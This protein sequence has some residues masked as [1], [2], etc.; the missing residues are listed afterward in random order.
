[1]IMYE[2][3]GLAVILLIYL[4]VLGVIGIA[5]LAAY[6]LQ[7]VGMYTLGKNRGMKYPWLAFI[8]YARVY[9]QGELCGPLAFKDRRMDNPG[10][11]LLVIPIASG[12]ITGIFTAIVW[13]G[14]LVNIVRMANQA[15]NSYYPFYNMFSGFGSGIMLLALLG[16]G[17]FTLA[18]SAVQKTLTVLVNRQIY[19]RYTDG[20]YAVMHAVLGIF[21]PLYT[22]VYFFIIRNRE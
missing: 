7:G 18:A 4:L 19:K 8:P 21:V 13:G 22:A 16:L 6:I 17:L 5:A 10:I 9:Y 20:N 3:N 14:V 15:I 12:V 1:M 11:W 2:S